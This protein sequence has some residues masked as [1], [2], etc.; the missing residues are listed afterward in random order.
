MPICWRTRLM[1]TS[2]RVISV[3]STT[4][5][6]RVGSS[7]RLQQRRS[8]DLPE[9]DGPMMNTSSLG[10]TARSMPFSTSRA[11]KDLCS[12]RTSRIAI[13]LRALRRIG[14]R[15]GVGAIDVILEAVLVG[16]RFGPG[17]VGRALVDGNR[18]ALQVLEPLD[19]LVALL[20]QEHVVGFHVALGEEHGLGALRSHG[21]RRDQEVVLL[22]V[23][24]GNE[25]RE[26]GAVDLDRPAQT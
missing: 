16:V 9:P 3:P 22:R 20:L 26:L 2:D 8:V 6:P 25:R 15:V 24:A 1:S 10:A 5:E 4:T 19:V 7:S 17:L 14:D 23:H 11:P 12:P 18:L 21:R 13:A